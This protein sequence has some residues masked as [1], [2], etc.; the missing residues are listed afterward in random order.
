M[1]IFRWVSLLVVFLLATACGGSSP[2]APSST[3]GTTTSTPVV[4][5]LSLTGT[6]MIGNQPAFTITQNGTGIAGTQIFSPVPGVGVVI[7]QTGTVTGTLG[8]TTSGSALAM[9]MK[10]TIVTTGIGELAGFAI[11]CVST[12]SWV[13]TATNTALTGTYTSGT[14]TCDGLGGIVTAPITGPMN[15]TKQ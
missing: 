6:W 7:T 8:G 2:S 10:T 11:T 12:D 3:S 1:R 5:S 15:Y 13:G 14:F 9:S 4:A